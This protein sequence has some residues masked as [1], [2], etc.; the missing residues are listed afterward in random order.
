MKLRN[1]KFNTFATCMV[2]VVGLSAS[3]I[4]SCG[5][6]LTAMAA[7]AAG[8][9]LPL[10]Q[11]ARSLEQNLKGPSVVGL[12]YVEFTV[13]GAVIQTAYQLW[14][15]GGTEIHNPNVD[16]RGGNVCLG[17]WKAVGHGVYRLTHRVWNY[18]TNGNFLGTVHLTETITLGKGGSAHCGTLALDFYDPSG[19]FLMEL[20]GT[21]TGTRI[22]VD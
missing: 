5:D 11:G 9:S 15:A 2:L 20:D 16:P 3:A 1:L 14:N 8:Q 4:A 10:Q 7:A 19:N 6:S 18:D 17:V 21:V 22:P 12:W 13:N